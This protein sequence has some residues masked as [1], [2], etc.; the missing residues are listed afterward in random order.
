MAQF[1]SVS[2]ENLVTPQWLVDTEHV[3]DLVSDVPGEDDLDGV[4]TSALAWILASASASSRAS[5]STA[6]G[7]SAT[8]SSS[9]AQSRC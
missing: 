1:A 3:E 7:G 6:K 4:S 5:G 9:A 8:S 2:I